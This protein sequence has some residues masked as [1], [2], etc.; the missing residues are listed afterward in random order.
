[1]YRF[2]HYLISNPTTIKAT[3]WPWTS[4]FRITRAAHAELVPEVRGAGQHAQG[5]LVPEHDALDDLR[6]I[7]KVGAPAGRSHF[8]P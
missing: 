5:L 4:N 7:G 8:A 6:D 1:M 3:A 2:I